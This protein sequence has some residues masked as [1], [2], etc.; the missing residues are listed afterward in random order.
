VLL[1]APALVIAALELRL[2]EK[3]KRK[4]KDFAYTHNGN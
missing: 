3:Q 1:A 2:P 4:L